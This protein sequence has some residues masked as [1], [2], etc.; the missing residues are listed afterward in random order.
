MDAVPTCSSKLSA[1]SVTTPCW[2]RAA[3]GRACHRHTI[4]IPQHPEHAG[5]GLAMQWQNH[6]YRC[7]RYTVAKPTWDLRC[8][9]REP[10]TSASI[11]SR[12]AASPRS[13]SSPAPGP[14]NLATP[15]PPGAVLS[16][17]VAMY[18]RV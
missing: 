9:V 11:I 3:A 5:R 1:T 2:S 8:T 10:L 16:L 17:T 13:A 6:S 7:L 12:I 4:K 15:E 14:L 18:L